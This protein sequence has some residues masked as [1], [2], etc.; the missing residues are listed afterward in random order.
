MTKTAIIVGAS[1]LVG[2][3]VLKLLLA[4][5][6]FEKVKTFVRKPLVISH[7]KLE[8]YII[9]FDFI[10]KSADLIKGN[11]LFCCLGTTIKTAGSK[12]EFK[13]VDYVYPLEFAKI[14]KQNG[15]N[16]FLIITSIGANKSSSNFYLKVKGDIE[17]VLEKLKFDSLVI[18]QP[19]ML[20]GERKGLRSGEIIGKIIMKPI[21]F[22][23]IGKFKKYK[24]I[25]ATIVAK[26]MI[27]LS[28][29][30]LPSVSIMQS[31]KLQ[32]IGGH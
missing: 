14:A 16:K 19:S 5:N 20:L 18:L 10:D 31:D 17:T 24:A 7:P 22:L 26:A 23:F 8:Q 29:S 1:G 11:V 28:K 12:E 4:D 3:E 25:E 2:N 30:D 21:S 13:K 32:K 6:D 9:N 15:V 27:Q